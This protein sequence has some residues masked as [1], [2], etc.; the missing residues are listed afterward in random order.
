M[1]GI[2]YE[3]DSIEL[4]GVIEFEGNKKFLAEHPRYLRGLCCG[5]TTPVRGSVLKRSKSGLFCSIELLKIGG[6]RSW[7]EYD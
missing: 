6:S 5:N 2:K 1:N 4:D 7:R 3:T